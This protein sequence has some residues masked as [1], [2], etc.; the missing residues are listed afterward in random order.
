MAGEREVVA[1]KM[2]KE[3]Q[4]KKVNDGGVEE[5]RRKRLS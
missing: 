2:E 3:E 1:R 5:M 4:K